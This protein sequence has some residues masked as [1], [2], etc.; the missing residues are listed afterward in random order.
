MG[1]FD[2]LFHKSQPQHPVIAAPVTGKAVSIQE[3]NDPTFSQEILGKGAAIIPSTGEI[4]APCDAKV[5]MMFD[6][7]HAV[8]LVSD[9]GM[10]ILIHVGLETVQLKGEH[11][12]THV[13]TGDTVKKGQLLIS[14]DREAIAAKGYDLITPIVLCNSD[15]FSILQT[16][17]GDITAG[18]PLMTIDG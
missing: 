11:Y 16:H 7:G 14:F 9:N 6:T 5:D 2:K 15:R 12:T 17:T 8:S 10:E 13:K 4:V 3:V 1:I 18:D